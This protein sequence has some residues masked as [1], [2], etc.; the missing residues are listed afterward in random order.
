MPIDLL[1]A[2]KASN[3]LPRDVNGVSASM[4][5][6]DRNSQKQQQE[7][8]YNNSRSLSAS[9]PAPTRGDYRPEHNESKNILPDGRRRSREEQDGP[10][11]AAECVGD[12]ETGEEEYAMRR[13]RHDSD[14]KNERKRDVADDEKWAAPVG[15]SI[16]A[17]VMKAG[18]DG[19]FVMKV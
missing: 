13:G 15:D 3:K 11:P 17:L 4:N 9:V 16:E 18:I 5:T 14:Q 19:I 7:T 8:G 12:E 1:S 6:A 10:L 2:N